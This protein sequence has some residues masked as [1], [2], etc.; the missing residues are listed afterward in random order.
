MQRELAKDVQLGEQRIAFLSDNCDAIE[1]KGYMKRFTP[2]QL[3]QMKEELSETAIKINDIEE[4][5]KEVMAEFKEKLEPL[6]KE[7]QRILVGLKNKSEHVVERCF[8][9]IDPKT[10]EVG[11]YNEE[12]ELV[13]SR[14]AYADE[15]QGT[16][17]QMK[18]TGTDE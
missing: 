12:G 1:E 3:T 11:Y 9:F 18:R 17:F 10:R 16:I 4:K 13:E 5:K 7:K 2:N 15:F 14:P 6:N 8:K